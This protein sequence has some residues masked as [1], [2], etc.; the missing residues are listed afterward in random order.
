M[1]R[2]HDR[3]Y[4]FVALLFLGLASVVV[5]SVPGAAAVN[6]A[7]GRV[8]TPVQRGLSGAAARV[9]DAVSGTRDL[10]AWQARATVLEDENARLKT[11]NLRLQGLER[12][13]RDLRES[14]KFKRARPDLDLMGA[15][16]I[17][18]AVAHEPGHLTR[19]IKLDVGRTHGVA[20]RMTVASP[21]GLVGQVVRSTEHWSDV[22]LI[23][24]PS[25]AVAGRID[26]SREAGMVFGSPSGELV[27]RYIPQDRPD[28]PPN[29]QVGDLVYT[30]GQSE[31]FAPRLLIGQVDE[32][33]QSDFETFQE[34]VIRPS[35]DFNALETVLII[36]EWLPP[37]EAEAAPA[38]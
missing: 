7:V 6:S 21:R 35:V 13:V 22:L 29:V 11:D 33:R 12:E 28:S 23:T 36:T 14:L 10:E 32:V 1:N 9:R 37:D 8:I 34:A 5:Q 17:G 19:A 27:M 18:A 38:R 30:S 16:I 31:R 3:Q 25:S 2:R 15:S 24:D 20:I 4:L 26:R